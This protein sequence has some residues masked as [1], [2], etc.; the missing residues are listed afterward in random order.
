M[1]QETTVSADCPPPVPLDQVAAPA[2]RL[3]AL[4]CD[5]HTH[6]F[7][8]AAVFPYAPDR[9]YTPPDAPFEALRALHRKLGISRGVIV[10]PGCHGYDMSAV[11]DALAKGGGQYRAVALL[12]S[13]ATAAEVKRLDAAGVRGVR[14]NFVAHLKN[15]AWSEV[16]D[17]ARLIA[18]FGWHLCIHS[19]RQSLPTLL[20]LLKQLDIP[21]VLD[22]MGRVAAAD[23]V[24]AALFRE[25]LA[26]RDHRQAW[27]KI[28]G[29]DRISSSGRR[30][31]DDGRPFVQALVESMA[32]RLLWGS[33]WPHPNVRG[34][35]P[36]DGELVD[37]FT[38][39]CPQR[40]DQERIL[41]SNPQTLYR[42]D[43]A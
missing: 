39:L 43:E 2:Q 29:I 17:M 18:P 41:V 36:N 25:L 32:D 9:T 20:P 42:F 1:K 16:R 13:M 34:D 4:A 31:Y 15:V 22:H 6:I 37:I 14:F 35:M 3:P 30:P 12:P 10:Q 38:Q 26:L 27:V 23:G 5:A 7:G 28:S 40:E 8:P 33:D 11:L 24:D 21:F 19:D